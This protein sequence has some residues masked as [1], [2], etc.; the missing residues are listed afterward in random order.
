MTEKAALGTRRKK[1]SL[2]PKNL[3]EPSARGAW[4]EARVTDL[5]ST[6]N[7][8]PKTKERDQVLGAWLE[9]HD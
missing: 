7:R 9:A 3:S 6:Q 8:I 1:L 4:L 2:R 5:S